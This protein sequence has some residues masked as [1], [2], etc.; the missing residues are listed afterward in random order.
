[1]ADA[2]ITVGAD[3]SAAERAAAMVKNAWS[4][5][6]G[7]IISAFG[8][9]TRA[10]AGDLANVALAHG[11]VNFSSQHQQVR[12]FEAATAHLAVATHSSLESM[13]SSYEATGLAIGKR[14]AEVAAWSKE[15]GDLTGNFKGAGEAIRGMSE[16]AAETGRSVEDYRGLAVELNT[17][18][19][20]AGDTSHVVGELTAQ[21]NALG[22]Q[23]GINAFTGQVEGLR[24]VISHFAVT[25][26]SDFTRVTAAAGVLGKGLNPIAAGRV[27]QQV[28]GTITGDP[29]GWSR[30]LGR[31]ITDEHG[32]IKEPTKVLQQ[33]G[34]R[35]MSMYG[36]DAKRGFQIQFGAEAGAQFYNA[37]KSGDMNHL[38]KIA[39]LPPSLQPKN[40]QAEY[41]AT[42]AGKRDIAGA[43]LAT[44]S[45]ALMGSATLLGHAADALQQFAAK[46]PITSSIA[47]GAAGAA[48]PGVIGAVAKSAGGALAGA[49]ATGLGGTALA[50]GGVG[51]AAGAGLGAGALLG[52]GANKLVDKYDLLGEQS[53]QHTALQERD[54]ETARLKR[55]RDQ[56]RAT[57]APIAALG[58]GQE[59]QESARHT[60]AGVL[61]GGGD[62]SMAAVVAALRAHSD[63]KGDAEA[64]AKAVADALK[65]MTLQVQN[66]SDTNVSLSVKGGSQ[67]GAAGSQRHG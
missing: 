66:A 48:V 34:Q 40:A 4:G 65:G 28:L 35:I 6:A 64:I 44:S 39:G 67:S 17:V 27:Q 51:L 12:E 29:I 3:A 25:S 13:R 37:M 43:Q 59:E 33:V 54:R 50:L 7:E 47:A 1:M 46:N 26:E 24:D 21:A 5:T 20:V 31:D 60:I 49:G 55:V 22:T 16:L 63:T 18:G 42:D 41:N 14:P 61:G 36:K 9:A 11:K 23:G 8:N 32:Q 56:V 2:K 58:V 30:F 15:V 62:K 38:D 10:V 57:N 45:R 19:G 52:Y 53:R